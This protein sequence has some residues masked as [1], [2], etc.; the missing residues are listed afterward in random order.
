MNRITIY[1]FYD[2]EGIVDFYVTNVLKKLKSYSRYIC[3][4]C[5]GIV[6]N[7]GMQRLRENADIVVTRD[8]IGYDAGAYKDII[9]QLYKQD[10]L[11]KYDQMLLVNGTF[12]GFFYDIRDIF[13]KSTDY[14]FCGLTGTEQK[15][16]NIFVNSYFIDIQ[17]KM[18]HSWEFMNFWIQMLYYNNFKDVLINFERK[19]TEYFVSCGYRMGI[20]FPRA[21]YM[22]QSYELITQEHYPILKAKAIEVV[23]ADRILQYLEKNELY[24]VKWITEYMKRRCRNGS[25]LQDIFDMGELYSFCDKYE[26]IY[27]YGAGYYGKKVQFY[28]N[29]MNFPFCGFIVTQR[30]NEIQSDVLEFSKLVFSKQAGIIL[31]MKKQYVEE[32]LSQIN[33]K[34]YNNCFIPLMK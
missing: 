7:D 23:E 9:M 15:D 29:E 4:V 25:I 19:F 28:L 20:L 12:F 24:P 2:K 16:G 34:F 31:A 26:K 8:N 3:V 18:L 11:K 1:V 27:I 5:N 32:V 30:D 22:T 14:D 17:K 10:E 6:Q 33:G 21:Y 13:E